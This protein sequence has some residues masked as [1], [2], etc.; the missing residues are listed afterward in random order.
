MKDYICNEWELEYKN[1]GFDV[2][3]G[4]RIRYEADINKIMGGDGFEPVAADDMGLYG[5]NG[6]PDGFFDIRLSTVG[7][8]VIRSGYHGDIHEV[9]GIIPV[10][11]K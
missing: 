10:V 6:T 9:I 3:D 8:T 11:D 2:L 5:N 1:V 7:L 4:L